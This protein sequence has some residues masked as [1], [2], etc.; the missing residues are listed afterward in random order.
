[1]DDNNG[2]RGNLI[3]EAGNESVAS[4]NSLR[5]RVRI[6]DFLCSIRNDAFCLSG[7]KLMD[8]NYF[9]LRKLLREKMNKHSF[10]DWLLK[11]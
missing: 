5:F 9:Q 4:R 11:R 2:W 6:H 8:F 3:D 1:V 10:F 7:E